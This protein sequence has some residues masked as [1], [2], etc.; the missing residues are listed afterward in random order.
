MDAAQVERAK[1][2]V[3]NQRSKLQKLVDSQGK[4][5]QLRREKIE[6]VSFSVSNFLLCDRWVV[7]LCCVSRNLGVARL[8]N[9]ASWKQSSSHRVRGDQL[10][11]CEADR[12]S[13]LDSVHATHRPL[14]HCHMQLND[15][16][17]LL[18]SDLP[19]ARS[20][21]YS[22]EYKVDQLGDCFDMVD[23]DRQGRVQLDEV[24]R[25]GTVQLFET[26]A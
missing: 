11:L 8:R 4:Q 18:R 12:C 6:Q 25:R 1:V 7:M 14:L 9:S 26:A 10:Q 16:D 13:T 22:L 3:S 24:E 17:V 21:S 15:A 19:R 20:R 5:L 2:H 23:A